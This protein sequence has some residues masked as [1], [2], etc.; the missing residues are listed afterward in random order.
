MCSIIGMLQYVLMDTSVSLMIFFNFRLFSRNPDSIDQDLNRPLHRTSN[1][2]NRGGIAGTMVW[3]REKSFDRLLIGRAWTLLKLLTK[4]IPDSA[5]TI[6]RVI[7]HIF[8]G[9][10]IQHSLPMVFLHQPT[11]S[12]L[13]L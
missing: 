1:A 4:G 2:S 6:S 7:G 13:L 10:G 8:I 12:L 11:A 5:I 3:R 9:L